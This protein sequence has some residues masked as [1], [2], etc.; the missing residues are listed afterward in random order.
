M[1]KTFFILLF[2]VVMLVTAQAQESN[3]IRVSVDAGFTANSAHDRK[4]GMGGTVGWLAQDNLLSF[5]PNNYISLSVKGFNNPYG[6]GKLFSSINNDANDGFTYIAPLVGYRI[7][8]SGVSEGFF[9]EPRI[10]VAFAGSEYTAFAFAPIAGYAYENFEF[11]AF[12]DM[13]FSGKNNP[14]GKKS[15]FTPGI[16]IAY[17]IR[18]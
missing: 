5:N 3:Y 17:N 14:I 6:D 4:F 12:F 11:G 9:V 10:G 18:F 7:T 15:F 16:S 1:K 2:A 13:G 8:Q